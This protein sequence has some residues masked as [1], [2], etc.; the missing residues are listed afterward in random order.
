MVGRFGFVWI[1]IIILSVFFVFRLVIT[2]FALLIDSLIESSFDEIDIFVSFFLLIDVEVELNIFD[3]I[4][5]LFSF[6]LEPIESGNSIFSDLISANHD[7]GSKVYISMEPLILSIELPFIH[8]QI[9]FFSGGQFT[10]LN[11]N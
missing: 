4:V 1:L 10:A 7:F 5:L 2:C 6:L 11:H 9:I 8:C 3:L